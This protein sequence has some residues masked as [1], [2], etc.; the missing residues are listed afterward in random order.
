MRAPLLVKLYEPGLVGADGAE[1]EPTKTTLL[2]E[3]AS[4]DVGLL[5]ELREHEKQAAQEL[6][7][8]TEKR[9]LTGKDGGPIEIASPRD[10]LARRVSQLAARQPKPSDLT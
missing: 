6:G 3:V 7:Q 4:L 9:E 5:K 10:E 8:W 2:V 1:L